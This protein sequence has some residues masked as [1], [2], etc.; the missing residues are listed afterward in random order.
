MGIET[1]GLPAEGAKI[2][3]DK[4]APDRLAQILKLAVGEEGVLALIAAGAGIITS[5]TL[6][7]TLATDDPS[8]VALADLVTATSEVSANTADGNVSTASM[9]GKLTTIIGHVDGLEGLLTTVNGKLDTLN[10]YA[11]DQATLN[12]AQDTAAMKSGSTSLTPRFAAIAASASGDNTIVAAV[13]GK[14]IRVLS[15]DYTAAAAVNVKWKSGAS[16]DKS[17]LT[18]LPAAG[19]GKA[20]QFNPVGHVETNVGEALVLNLSAAQAVGG[21]LTYIEV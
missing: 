3:V 20:K 21:E 17:G 7:I 5:G 12:V 11:S 15:Y 18:Y 6:R 10:G 16:N 8:A 4:I 19:W 2:L 13:T 14:K 1:V 9:D